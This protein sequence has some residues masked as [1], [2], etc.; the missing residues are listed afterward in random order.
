LGGPKSPQAPH[1]PRA[2]ADENLSHESGTLGELE[3]KRVAETRYPNFDVMAEADAWDE[4]T[5][6]IIERRLA[7]PKRPE[8]LTPSESQTLRTI[9]GHLLYDER[10]DVL[11]YVL[12][13][14]DNRLKDPIGEAQRKEDVPPEADL[15]RRGLVALDAV[16][17]QR[18]GLPFVDCSVESQF[19]MLAALQNG[20]LEP[21][22]EF[23]GIPQKELFKKLLGLS[24]E[25]F[26]SH[27][28][29]WSEIGYAGPAYPR[30]YYRIEQG[31][32]DPWEPRTESTT[33][34]Y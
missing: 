3:V 33:E 8:F 4:H 29:V 2:I 31:V 25:A 16:A 21:V 5:R 26:A 14:I 32:T 20:A 9:V 12:S 13:H 17:R 23:A 24:V 30:G 18:H 27:P 11:G 1:A 28:A 19:A 10:V 15:I 7:P 34:T 6:S 22:P